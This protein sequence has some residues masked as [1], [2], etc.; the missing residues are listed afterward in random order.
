MTSVMTLITSSTILSLNRTRNSTSALTFA[1]THT[2]RLESLSFMLK[3]A[4][5]HRLRETTPVSCKTGQSAADPLLNRQ[6]FK[7]PLEATCTMG[8][9]DRSRKAARQVDELVKNVGVELPRPVGPTT[10]HPYSLCT[11]HLSPNALPRTPHIPGRILSS[12]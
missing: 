12:E 1:R 7:R 2:E 3:S 8:R 10:P 11:Q 5:A 9:T 6:V 4:P